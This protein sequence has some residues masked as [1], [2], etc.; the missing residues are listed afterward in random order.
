[1]LDTYTPVGLELAYLGD[2]GED[3]GEAHERPVRE[4]ET[5]RAGVDT[6]GKG[7]ANLPRPRAAKV[8]GWRMP[9]LPLHTAMRI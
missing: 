1:M 4:Q 8:E 6:L 5:A 3:L 9:D 2:P 7:A